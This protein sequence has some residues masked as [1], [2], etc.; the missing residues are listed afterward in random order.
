MSLE[1]EIDLDA[2]A[3]EPYAKKQRLNDEQRHSDDEDSVSSDEEEEDTPTAEAA[4]GVPKLNDNERKLFELRLRLNQCRKANYDEVVQEDRRS[5]LDPAAVKRQQKEKT[6]E[7]IEEHRKELAEYG[8][9]PGKYYMHETAEKVEERDKKKK[10]KPTGEYFNNEALFQA[11]KKRTAEIPVTQEEYDK[12]KGKLGDDM[13]RD[14]HSM[15]HGQAPQPTRLQ[16]DRMVAELNK[17]AEKREKF[18]RRRPFYEDADVDYIN[19]RNAVFNKKLD[20]FYGKH[21]QD[22]KNALERGTA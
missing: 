18:S 3:P 16:V 21:T 9:D 1:E 11:Y 12:L 7:R 15:L 13:Y 17:V 19:D 2:P 10:K 22:I 6:R 14:A 8:E 4:A 5:K 20:R